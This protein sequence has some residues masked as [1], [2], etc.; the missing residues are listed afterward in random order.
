MSQSKT[1]P[2]AYGGQ[3]IAA[4]SAADPV[5]GRAIAHLGMLSRP[6]HDDLFCAL[7]SSMVAQL[8]SAKSADTVWN[9][10]KARFSLTPQA[11]ANADPNAIQACGMTMRKARAICAA[12]QYIA[13]GRLPLESLKNLSDEDAIKALTLLP[14]VGLWTAE[15]V[16]LHGLERPNILS[17]GDMAIRRGIKRL[18]GL[19]SL[20]REEFDALYARYCPYASVA[21][22]YL[23]KI[24]AE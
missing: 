21:S 16:L 22:I 2:F 19:S 5:L 14:G 7:L 13:E 20:S 9:R 8:I 10:L 24:A 6:V 11:I 12:A 1:H 15:M 4:L 17:F 23:W 3:E 18:Y